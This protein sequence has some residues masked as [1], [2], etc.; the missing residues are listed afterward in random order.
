MTIVLPGPALIDSTWLYQYGSW[1][2]FPR[3]R[4][5]FLTTSAVVT[6]FPDWNLRPFRSVNVSVLESL[7]S[8]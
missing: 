2:F 1:P 6:G 7:L 8:E 4:F 3:I 5:Q